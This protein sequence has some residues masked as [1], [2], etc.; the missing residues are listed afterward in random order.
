MLEAS[1]QHTKFFTKCNVVFLVLASCTL[2]TQRTG[3]Q[4]LRATHHELEYMLQHALYSA[5]AQIKHTAEQT[6]V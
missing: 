6:A 1:F 4:D 2:K 5:S 3:A